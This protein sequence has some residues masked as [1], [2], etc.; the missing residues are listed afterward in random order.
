[1][2]FIKGVPK[3]NQIIL[4][5]T[6]SDIFTWGVFAAINGFVGLYLA[7]KLE[8][9]VVQ[10]LGVGIG[11]YSLAQ[12]IV[13]IPVGTLIDKNKSDKDDIIILFIGDILMGMPFLFFPFIESEYIYYILQFVIGIGAG[14][15]VVSWRKLFAKNLDK[16]KEGL[17]YGTYETIMSFSI[18][19]LSF[20]AGVIA[21]INESFFDLV[22]ISIGILIMSG[23]FWSIKIYRAKSRKT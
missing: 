3:V 4:Y 15:N 16:D 10:I 5:L 12:G 22:M 11:I 13:Q 21:N 8:I 14:M 2:R 1:M 18:A 7:E 17:E 6:A 9:D 19:F 23:G 20:L